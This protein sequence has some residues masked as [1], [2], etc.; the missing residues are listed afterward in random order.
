MTPRRWSLAVAALFVALLAWYVLYTRQIVRAL[1]AD[2][3]NFTR[4]Y[5]EVVEGL[6]DPSEGSSTF[7]LIQLQR[8]II[9]AGV[10]FI[11]TGPG[12]AIL[13]VENLPFDADL[14]TPDGQE[15]LR[16][17]LGT[18]D[19]RN[20][21]IG[22]PEFQQVHYGDPPLVTRLRWIPWLQGGGLVL[23]VL[24]GATLIR[25]QRR[26]ESER[27]WTAMARELAHQLGTP[28]SSLQGWLEVLRLTP[29]ERPGHLGEAEVVRELEDDIVRLERITRRFE[30]VGQEPELKS[31]DL[32][33]VVRELERYLQS[34]LPS[35]GSEVELTVNIPPDLPAVKG[36][37][38]LLS[39][40]LEN[41]VKNSLDA[42]AGRGGSIT[43]DCV[44]AEPGWV[45][46]RI[47]DSGPGIDDAVRDRLFDPG[48][49]TKSSG[50]GVGLA[51]ARRIVDGVHGGRI[52]LV[53]EWEPGATMSIRLPTWR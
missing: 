2:S 38:V 17:Y 43:I 15:R 11:L 26:V 7:A 39:W 32:Y 50:W 14:G 29:E 41:V 33:A 8:L 19:A 37:P 9:E 34:R 3:E 52:E 47:A 12:D 10:P 35:L 49:T 48:V 25:Y 24:V 18:L 53:S 27:A 40:A 6:T 28:I 20:P 36:H 23:T 42:L 31:L 22:D 4:V 5:A 21:P 44:E 51:L 13:G 46:V 1:R 16:T 30:L 45:D